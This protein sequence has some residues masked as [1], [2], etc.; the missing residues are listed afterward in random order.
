MMQIWSII[1]GFLVVL[2][3]LF[4]FLKWARKSGRQEEQL[5]QIQEQ[6]KRNRLTDEK[7]EAVRKKYGDLIRNTPDNWDDVTRVQ[8]KENPVSQQSKGPVSSSD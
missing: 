8:S 1:G 6:I 4:S 7:V 5:D 2:G 3:V